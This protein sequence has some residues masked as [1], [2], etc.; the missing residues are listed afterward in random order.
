MDR[1]AS[2]TKSGIKKAYENKTEN[3][4]LSLVFTYGFRAIIQRRQ[5]LKSEV[6]Y[7]PIR[8]QVR[9]A[10]RKEQTTGHKV[11]PRAI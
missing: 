2:F 7:A 8:P 4:R 9:T 6:G 5:R 1:Q 11:F 10:R 3:A